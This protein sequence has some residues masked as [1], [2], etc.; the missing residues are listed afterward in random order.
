MLTC[1]DRAAGLIRMD[2]C[3]S[4]RAVSAEKMG[5]VT[6]ARGVLFLSQVPT[7]AASIS[8]VFK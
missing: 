5:L 6:R 3:S 2:Q 4:Y 8:R 1:G 7:A